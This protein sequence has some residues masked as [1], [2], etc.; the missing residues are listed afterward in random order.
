[1]FIIVLFLLV[2]LT[3]QVFSLIHSFY[4]YEEVEF[5]QNIADL[6]SVSREVKKSSRLGERDATRDFRARGYVTCAPQVRSEDY[7][8]KE[9]VDRDF[10]DLS[11]R[12]WIFIRYDTCTESFLVDVRSNLMWLKFKDL[13][14]EQVHRLEKD[15]VDRI[16]N[17]QWR[18]MSRI[19][20]LRLQKE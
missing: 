1:M 6:Q 2:A 5:R 10:E 7:K 9:D 20:L 3:A 16:Q 17:S 11:S 15:F 14:P 13:S 8:C 4:A 19:E 18:E 12:D